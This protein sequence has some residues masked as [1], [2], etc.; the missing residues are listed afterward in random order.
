MHELYLLNQLTK[1]LE[2]IALMVC[3][4]IF[5]LNLKAAEEKDLSSYL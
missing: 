2:T 5:F 1:I 3:R 4:A